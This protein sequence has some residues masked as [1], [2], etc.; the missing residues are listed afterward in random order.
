[1]KRIFFLLSLIIWNM[2]CTNITVI[3]GPTDQLNVFEPRVV[4]VNVGDILNFIPKSG[5]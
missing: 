2:L 5:K 4:D 1:M 3:V